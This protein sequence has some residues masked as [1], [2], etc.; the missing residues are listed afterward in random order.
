M[1][2]YAIL[3]D[4]YHINKRMNGRVVRLY[5]ETTA[6]EQDADFKPKAGWESSFYGEPKS[7]KR[8]VLDDAVKFGVELTRINHSGT[9]KRKAKVSIVPVDE[10]SHTYIEVGQVVRFGYPIRTFEKYKGQ[11]RKIRNYNLEDMLKALKVTIE[12]DNWWLPES[13]SP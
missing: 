13:L 6:F 1:I 7:V 5:T 8:F 11:V 4:Y 12:K 10:G 2:K 9:G 3:V